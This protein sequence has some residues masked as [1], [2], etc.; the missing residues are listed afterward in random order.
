MEKD[1]QITKRF[2]KKVS[3]NYNSLECSTELTTTV[4]VDSG[5]KLLEESNK[6]YEQAKALTEMD[7]EKA[8]RENGVK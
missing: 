7:I 4:K 2:T 1:Y 5:E 6:L 3:F 8:L